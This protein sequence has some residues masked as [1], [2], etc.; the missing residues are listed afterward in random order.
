MH[1]NQTEYL[2]YTVLYKI[3]FKQC[4]N[5]Y[6]LGCL[7]VLTHVMFNFIFVNIMSNIYLYWLLLLYANHSGYVCLQLELRNILRA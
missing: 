2:N 1:C 7:Y 6:I 3:K 4:N 5:L